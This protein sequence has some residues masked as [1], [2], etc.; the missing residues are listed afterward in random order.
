M[1]LLFQVLTTVSLLNSIFV[2]CWKFDIL[3]INETKV[4]LARIAIYN[5]RGFVAIPR[6]YDDQPFTVVEIPWPERSIYTIYDTKPFPNSESQ[7]S[8]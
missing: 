3:G 7:V 8:Y 5:L 4:E 2:R 1:T 6:V